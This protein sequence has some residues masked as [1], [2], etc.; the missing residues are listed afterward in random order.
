[1]AQKRTQKR[2]YPKR[3]TPK[4]KT[5][6]RKTPKRK[7]PKRKTPKRKTPKRKRNKK[8]KKRI[9]AGHG[10]EEQ[11][12]WNQLED[13]ADKFNP[14]LHVSRKPDGTS[15]KDGPGGVYWSDLA[16]LS[17]SFEERPDVSISAKRFAALQTS[18]NAP[19]LW[20]QLEDLADK[21]NP[22]LVLAS[23]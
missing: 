13:L 23:D 9:K 4:R 12:H 17:Y 15:W 21:F 3:K 1:M 22:P 8:T 20:G 16:D 6:K 7:N 11:I 18:A 5:P 14:R 2:K 19:I 10:A